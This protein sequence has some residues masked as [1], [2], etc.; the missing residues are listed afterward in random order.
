MSRVIQPEEVIREPQWRVTWRV[1]KV[2]FGWDT[3]YIT[4]L[5]PTGESNALALA[6]ALR[7]VAELTTLSKVRGVV[8]EYRYPQVDATQWTEVSS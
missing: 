8:V 1:S 7:N 4:F 3:D 6:R 5:G 2:E